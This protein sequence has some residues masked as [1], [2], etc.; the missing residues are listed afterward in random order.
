[1]QHRDVSL[2]RFRHLLCPW[3]YGQGS[4]DPHLGGGGKGTRPCIHCISKSNCTGTR[5]RKNWLGPMK[6]SLLNKFI[7][8]VNDIQLTVNFPITNDAYLRK[9]KL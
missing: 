6:E 9:A 4:R 2:R 5:W 8:P 7:T 3:L 1:L